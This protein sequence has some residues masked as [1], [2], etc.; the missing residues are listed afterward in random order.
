MGRD[1]RGLVVNETVIPKRFFA[2][3]R[4]L[5]CERSERIVSFFGRKWNSIFRKIFAIFD[6]SLTR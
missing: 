2:G 5:D 4:K 6:G 1:S 3:C